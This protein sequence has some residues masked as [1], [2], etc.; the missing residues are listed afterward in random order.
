MKRWGRGVRRGRKEMVLAY[1]WGWFHAQNAAGV[2]REAG[3]GRAHGGRPPARQP[4][5]PGIM[6]GGHTYT[7]A[8]G[9]AVGENKEHQRSAGSTC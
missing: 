2:G 3:R 4:G 6:H 8:A 1:V 9:P 7:T 5:P